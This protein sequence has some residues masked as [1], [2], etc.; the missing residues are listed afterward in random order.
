MEIPIKYETALKIKSP[1]KYW[2]NAHSRGKSNPQEVSCSKSSLWANFLTAAA[3]YNKEWSVYHLFT[4]FSGQPEE[5]KQV[6]IQQS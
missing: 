1:G 2:V 5:R 6:M 3:V 4:L